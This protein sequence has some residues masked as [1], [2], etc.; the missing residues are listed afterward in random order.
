MNGSEGAGA[1]ADARWLKG[2][3]ELESLNTGGMN[4]ED[5]GCLC[6]G[7]AVVIGGG[8]GDDSI[9]VLRRR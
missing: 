5:G 9:Q 7:F 4:S 6:F 2:T 8:P 1:G 3:L